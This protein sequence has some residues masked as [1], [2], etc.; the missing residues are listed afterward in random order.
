ML[1]AF[2][3]DK[4]LVTADYDLPRPIAKAVHAARDQGHQI[5]VLTGRPL[6]ATTPY[7]DL[8]GVDAYYSVN[9]GSYVVGVEKQVLRRAA[10]DAEQTAAILKPYLDHHAVEYS[11]IADDTLYVR[12][13]DDERWNW[14]HI[15][16]RTV[17]KHDADAELAADKL[18]F[19]AAGRG[20]GIAEHVTSLYPDLIL[21][22]W[23]EDYLEVTAAKSDKGSA[24]AL[25][26][27]ELNI[28]K[29]NVIA[30]GDGPNDVTMLR[31]AGRGV[32]VGERAH[33]DAVAAASERAAAPE[34]LGVKDWLERNVL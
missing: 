25:I 13:P 5:S 27:A 10:L 20:P 1:L 26:A 2:D 28:G 32:A 9:H 15:A 24:L 19:A 18:V 11:L 34:E 6:A 3:L 8:L 31:W 29:E 7:L 4:T 33:P 12:D 17:Q 22:P 14:A 16:N 30:F 23:E 21:Y